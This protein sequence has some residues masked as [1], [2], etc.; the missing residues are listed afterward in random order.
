MMGVWRP[1]H[2]ERLCRN[3]TC[4]VLHQVGVSFDLYC[5][6]RK[7]RIKIWILL[8]MGAWRPKHVVRL[9]RNKTCTVLHQV[10]VPFDLNWSIFP[11]NSFFLRV[12]EIT[13]SASEIITNVRPVTCGL[14][15]RDWRCAASL[16]CHRALSP[17]HLAG[18][19]ATFFVASLCLLQWRVDQTTRRHAVCHVL[20]YVKRLNTKFR[21]TDKRKSSGPGAGHLQFSTPFM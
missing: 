3:K 13:R 15:A 4:T 18:T 19:L 2:V 7:H 8:M 6:A 1:K 21:K 11:N 16:T 14:E 9:C 20:S 10:G 17:R 12:A 5:D